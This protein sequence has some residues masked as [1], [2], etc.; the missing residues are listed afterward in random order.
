MIATQVQ[1]IDSAAP[2][3]EVIG[4]AARLVAAGQVVAFPT[5]TVYGIGCRP[6]DEGAVDGIYQ[7]KGRPRALPLVL[8][9]AGRECLQRY[10]SAT[11]PELERAA[12]RFWPGPLTVIAAAGE[13]AP[14]QLVA[15]GTIGIRI[16]RHPV[17]LA[18]VRQCGGALATTSANLSGRGST[19]DPR[20]VLE[21]LGGRIALLLDAGQASMGVES[22]VVDFTTQPPTLLR[23]GA[24]GADELRRVIGHITAA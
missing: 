7:A 4:D 5:D 10:M 18:L 22:T 23:A 2:D 9:V 6:D 13:R 12:N 20:Q 21:Q 1:P 24:I 11:T 14:A 17:A 19:S 16:P 8:F 3:P 15:R